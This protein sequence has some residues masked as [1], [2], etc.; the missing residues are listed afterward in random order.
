MQRS[1]YTSPSCKIYFKTGQP[2]TVPRD[3]IRMNVELDKT[4]HSL[5]DSN[6]S[7]Q[8]ESSVHVYGAARAYG[9]SVLVELAKENISRLARKLPALDIIVLAEGGCKFLLDDDLWF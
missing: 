1:P 3:L 6:V 2:F 7:I 4:G 5:H 9:F 8:F